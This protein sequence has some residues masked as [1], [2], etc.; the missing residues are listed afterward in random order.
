MWLHIVL[1]LLFR[2]DKCICLLWGWKIG[3]QLLSPLGDQI[4]PILIGEHFLQNGI[5]I[6]YV[7]NLLTGPYTTHPLWLTAVFNITHFLLYSWELWTMLHCWFFVSSFSLFKWRQG[8]VTVGWVHTRAYRCN[9]RFTCCSRSFRLITLRCTWP[10]SGS[11][12]CFNTDTRIT[13]SDVILLAK[14]GIT[15][16]STWCIYT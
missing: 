15:N 6:R 7:L 8:L 11:F 12:S 3:K 16:K 13:L 5:S 9:D 1:V 14:F 2:M 10:S 4:T